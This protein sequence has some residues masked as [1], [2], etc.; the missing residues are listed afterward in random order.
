MTDAAVSQESWD[1]VRDLV[2]LSE[3]IGAPGSSVCR[4]CD[5][6]AGFSHTQA[7][8]KLDTSSKSGLYESSFKNGVQLQGA[9]MVFT[10]SKTGL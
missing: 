6:P 10:L 1:L 2:L 4:V 8:V 3:R 5:F 7:D 9:V